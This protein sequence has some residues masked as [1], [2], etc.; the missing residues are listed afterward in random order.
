M[1]EQHTPFCCGPSED[2]L[3][4]SP[5]QRN[6]LKANHVSRR[7]SAS[8][9]T[10]HVVVEI[11]IRQKPDQLALPWRLANRRARRPAAGCF[12]STCSRNSATSA[13]RRARYA[14]T[15]SRFAST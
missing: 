13:C 1:R 14:S 15:R 6:V 12:F 9:T 3:V 10:D 4:W 2:A 7:E 5:T 8:Q 11:L